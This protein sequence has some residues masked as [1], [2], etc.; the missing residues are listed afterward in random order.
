VSYRRIRG[1]L[2]VA[3]ALVGMLVLTGC[4][5]SAPDLVPAPGV[6]PTSCGTVRLAVN[7]WVG[8][9]ADVAV[10]SYLARR[11]LGC[12]VQPKAEAE[13]DSWKHLAAGQVDAILENWGHDDLKKQYID[14]EKVAVEAGLTGN[15]G[16]IGWYVPPWMKEKYPDITDWKSLKKYSDLFKTS[17][18]GSRGQFLDGDPT[19]VTNDKALVRN[20]GLDYR[21]VYAGSEDKLIAAFR[22]A[23]KDRKPLLGYFYSPQWLLSEIDLVHIPLPAYTPG[24]DANPTTVRCDY[25]PYDLDK[26]E[27][28]AFAYSGSPAAELIK[29]FRWTNADQNQVAR[30]ITNGMTDD[31]AAKKWLDA[32]RKVWRK[33]L[34]AGT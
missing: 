32:N 6:Q 17:K 15:Q 2:A 20:L 29:N 16:L 14:Q 22:Q 31:Q 5:A 12:T 25:Q 9:E 27:N 21:V 1:R 11:E 7:P 23:Q 24:C 26:I 19:Y 18:S 33:W 8:Y 4:G 10:V 13:A 34:P 3:L 28:K 30:D